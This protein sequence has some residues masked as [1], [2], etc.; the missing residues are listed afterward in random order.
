MTLTIRHI[1]VLLK[2]TV[3]GLEPFDGGLYVDCTLGRG[4]HS[5]A[6][7]ESANCRVIG[8]DRDPEAIS[9]ST[10]RLSQ[11]SDRF[12]AVRGTFGELSNI[13]DSLSI[14]R[15]DGLMADLGVSS[16]QLEDAHRGFSFQTAGPL[17]MRM[18]PETLL[19]ASELVNEMGEKELAN[20][21][22]QYGEERQSRSIARYIVGGRPW[23]DTLE[24][25]NA[26]AGRFGRKPNRIHPATRTFQALRIA[27]NGELDQIAALLPQ[28]INRLNGN[29]KVAIISFHSLEDRIVKQFFA[30]ESGRVSERDAYGHPVVAPRIAPPSRLIT[31][32]K[33]DPNPRA[34]SARLRIARRLEWTS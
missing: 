34:R 19:T 16:P 30:R 12:T 3:Q 1:P 9:D 25:A 2:E 14:Q 27:V 15:I 23:G 21:I 29:G 11:Y 24:L 20:I 26:M 5:K 22:F 31:P 32:D 13:L 6:L 10:E 8:L 4:G 7:L 28:A 18:D 33:D 17:D